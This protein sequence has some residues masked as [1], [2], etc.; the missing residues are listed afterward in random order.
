MRAKPAKSEASSR[1]RGSSSRY[2]HSTAIGAPRDRLAEEAKQEQRSLVR[3][4]QV[5]EDDQHRPLVGAIE[6][7]A[8]H[9][10]EQREA[11]AFRIRLLRGRPCRGRGDLVEVPAGGAH[12]LDP[13]P[14][15]G[16]A[17]L[18]PAA[19][20][21]TPSTRVPPPGRPPPASNR[22]LPMPASPVTIITPP[23]PAAASSSASCNSSSS[24]PRP[25]NGR[26]ERRL[27][28]G[29]DVAASPQGGLA[30]GHPSGVFLDARGLSSV[31]PKQAVG[32]E[33]GQADLL[34]YYE[35]AQ[36]RGPA[37]HARAATP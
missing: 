19:A 11:D 29:P 7:E 8:R 26:E 3:G 33:G 23:R 14:V 16:C 18:L 13:R 28:D 30:R 20:G 12:D 17:A 34:A 10:V 31:T 22:V 1:T 32:A 21:E 2:E 37:G 9:R 25:T 6:Q 27:P 5:L 15:G 36:D 4:V 24:R 35:E